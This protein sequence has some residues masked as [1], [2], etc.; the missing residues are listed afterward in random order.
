[1]LDFCWS[2]AIVLPDFCW[3]SCLDGGF[4]TVL[5]DFYRGLYWDGGLAIDVKAVWA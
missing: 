5:P 1:V 4:V 3:G 2:F